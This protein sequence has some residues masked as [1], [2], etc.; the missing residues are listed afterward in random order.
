[1]LT[2]P[3]LIKKLVGKGPVLT[4]FSVLLLTGCETGTGTNIEDWSNIPERHE[5]TA[6]RVF[7]THDVLFSAG[8]AVLNESEKTRLGMFLDAA[9]IG[10][11]DRVFLVPGNVPSG[12]VW[13]LNVAKFLAA[14]NVQVAPLPKE[15]GVGGP[16][17]QA[18]SVVV[19]RFVVS[20]PGC[21]DWSG[22]RFT[23]NNVPT[24][25]WGCA[26]AINLGRMIARP[27]DLV[28][29]RAPGAFDGE[30]GARSVELYRKGETK[31]L[32]QESVGPIESQQQSTSPSSSG[33]GN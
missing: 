20:L 22:E 1:M 10:G 30:L 4:I 29:G 6:K 13:A 2:G 3:Q 24:S 9:A 21:P 15:I 27:E 11:T 5:A 28:R 26:N 23:Y 14:R 18:V 7:Y 32:T 25:N 33:Q 8:L 19:S 31:P 16:P 17:G 12:R